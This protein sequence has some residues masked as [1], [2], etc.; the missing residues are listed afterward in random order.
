MTISTT[1]R[2]PKQMRQISLVIAQNLKDI[3]S[4][5]S[6][7]KY[8]G[9]DS[10]FEHTTQ[11]DAPYK[12]TICAPDCANR[13]R[14]QQ[15]NGLITDIIAPPGERL[16]VVEHRISELKEGFDN[17]RSESIRVSA[18][19]ATKEEIQNIEK[20]LDR[21]IV[22]EIRT[23]KSRNTLKT[24]ALIVTILGLLLSMAYNIINLY[25]SFNL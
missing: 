2:K 5:K 15:E 16:A 6:R 20:R 3:Q 4:G 7:G 9:L 12:E 10:I 11:R 1:H 21:D 23:I 22:P 13:I 8:P 18:T 24:V 17:H 19:Y 25:K 14:G